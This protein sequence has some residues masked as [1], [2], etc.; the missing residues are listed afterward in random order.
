MKS[1]RELIAIA[2]D[3]RT[4]QSTTISRT[5]I[6]AGRSGGADTV[7]ASNVLL[8]DRSRKPG[9]ALWQDDPRPAELQIKT[10]G[11]DPLGGPT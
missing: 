2:G 10:G 7:F 3:V 4:G 5:R 1:G 8:T 6:R 11:G 9:S